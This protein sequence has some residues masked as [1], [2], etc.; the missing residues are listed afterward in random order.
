MFNQ[1]N[2]LEWDKVF[3]SAFSPLSGF[4]LQTD[5][6][7]QSLFGTY[8][9]IANAGVPGREKIL[10]IHVADSEFKDTVCKSCK[11]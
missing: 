6:K 11:K 5:N 2:L 3:N 1:T 8:K 9:C 4:I 7:E 10:T